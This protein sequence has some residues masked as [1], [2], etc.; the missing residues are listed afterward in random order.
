MPTVFAARSRSDSASG[1]I[2]VGNGLAAARIQS[3]T[4]ARI[5]QRQP[6][7]AH[8]RQLGETVRMRLLSRPDRQFNPL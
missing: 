2:A 1:L 8:L 3:A 4:D 6:R 7:R 5:V